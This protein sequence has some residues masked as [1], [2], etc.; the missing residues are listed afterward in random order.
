MRWNEFTI[1]DLCTKVTD[2]S[3]FSPQEVS[4][5]HPMF[6][7]KDMVENGFDYS[8]V[9]RISKE[10]YMK[11]SKGDCKP[12]KDDILI[13]KDG[14][15]LK[16]VFVCKEEKEE[17]ILSS[18]AILR[19]DKNKIYPDYFKHLLRAPSVKGMMES[20][21]SGS[22]LPRIVLKDFKKMKLSIPDVPTQR[23]IASILSA[24]DDLIE[25][26]NKRIKLLEE[27]ARELYNEWFVR[28]R[29]PGYREMKLV[30]GVPEG[31][32]INELKK[33]GIIITG[34]TPS[35]FIKEYYNGETPFIKT[36]DMHGNMFIFHT[37][38]YISEKGVKSQKNQT[39]PAGSIVVNCI[40]ALAGSV[41]ITTQ[42]SQ[43]NQQIH[44]IKLHDHIDLEYLFWAIS[45]LKEMIHQYGNTGSTMT[46]LSKGKYENLKILYPSKKLILE[47]HKIVL[48]IFEQIKILLKQNNQLRQIR[49]RLLPRLISGKLQVKPL[50][51]SNEKS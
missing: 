47:Y 19:P 31:W 32:E 7:V 43:T 9:K 50:K 22:A 42:I 14:S 27:T 20:F 15:Y 30:K 13:A 23:R 28:M 35:T 25:I 48:P 49:D 46:N 41:S 26:N 8:K 38:E 3:H 4:S 29:F 10:D 34:K 16:H 39:L 45:D 40:G 17:G 44:S 36:P 37:E 11:L 21:V 1:G 18:I 12:R 5:G 6:S 51:E 24:Y 33:I 2:G